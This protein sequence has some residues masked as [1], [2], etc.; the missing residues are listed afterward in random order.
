MDTESYIYRIVRRIRIGPQKRAVLY[1][2]VDTVNIRPLY[3]VFQSFVKHREEIPMAI[4][5][6]TGFATGKPPMCNDHCP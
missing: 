6:I 5:S 4:S 3:G 2:L 1:G